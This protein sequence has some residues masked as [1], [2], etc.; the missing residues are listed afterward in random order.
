MAIGVAFLLLQA[1]MFRGEYKFSHAVNING[2]KMVL[3]HV[4]SAEVKFKELSC[5]I[6][7]S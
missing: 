7:V 1:V 3:G 4:T 2:K 6:F 5:K